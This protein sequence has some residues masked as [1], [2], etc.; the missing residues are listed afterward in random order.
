MFFY[1]FEVWVILRIKREIITMFTRS[2]DIYFSLALFFSSK[3]HHT[4]VTLNEIK[5]SRPTAL[6]DL[7]CHA[8][9]NSLE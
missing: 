9:S 7:Q 2:G 8:F 1:T 4:N 5:K 6:S 3:F